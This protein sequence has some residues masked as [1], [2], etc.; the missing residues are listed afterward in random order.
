M[1]GGGIMRS[2]EG[3]HENARAAATAPLMSERVT[4]LRK[5]GEALSFRYWGQLYAGEC[6]SVR[7]PPSC[8]VIGFLLG[9]AGAVPSRKALDGRK[10]RPFLE[11]DNRIG[12]QGRALK[13]RASY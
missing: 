5:Q 4:I 11:L 9:D 3:I 2:G 13:A 12:D 7:A 8:W 1:S 6:A 10:S